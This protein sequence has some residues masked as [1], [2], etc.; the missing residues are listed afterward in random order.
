VP[1]SNEDLLEMYDPAVIKTR[2]EMTK[3]E[4]QI[5]LAAA[6]QINRRTAEFS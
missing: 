4:L 2:L 5:A 3:T 1:A 6:T